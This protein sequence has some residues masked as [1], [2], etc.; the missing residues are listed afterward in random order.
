MKE[1]MHLENLTS[2]T[3]HPWRLCFVFVFAFPLERSYTGRFK[4]LFS[5]LWQH[6]TSADSSVS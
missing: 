1:G 6:G 2:A 4:H 5:W 3:E